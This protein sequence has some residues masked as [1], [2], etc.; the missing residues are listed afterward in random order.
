MSFFFDDLD[1]SK[2]KKNISLSL[3]SL[4]TLTHS[5]T[6][7]LSPKGK[8]NKTLIHSLTTSL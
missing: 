5:L 7:A 3:S 4:F 8:A 6:R 2:G 1:L